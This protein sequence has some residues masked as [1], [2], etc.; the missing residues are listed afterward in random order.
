MNN[1]DETV[2]FVADIKQEGIKAKETEEDGSKKE[3]TIE[4]RRMK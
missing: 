4:K 1:K 2:K 3:D